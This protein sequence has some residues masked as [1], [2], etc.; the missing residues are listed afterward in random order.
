MRYAVEFFF[1]DNTERYV[2]DIWNELKAQGITAFMADIE[3]LRPHITV[4]VYNSEIPIEKFITQFINVTK[5]MSKIDVKFDAISIFPTTGTVFLSPTMTFQLFNTH[6]DYCNALKEYDNFDN[7]NGFNLPDN[8]SP[9]CT[10]ATRLNPITLISALECCLNKFKPLTGKINEIGIVK[11]D[12]INDNCI[13]SKT[14]FST[15]LS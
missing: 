12:Y 7:Y 3:E 6:G 13:S 2:K 15:V 8:W 14:I 5:A 9:H 10:L 11:L 1:D 4:A